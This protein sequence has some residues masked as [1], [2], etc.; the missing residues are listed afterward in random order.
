M[1]SCVILHVLSFHCRRF[2]TSFFFSRG[3]RITEQPDPLSHALCGYCNT[4]VITYCVLGNFAE[5]YEGKGTIDFSGA[6][7]KRTITFEPRWDKKASTCDIPWTM[8]NEKCSAA[9]KA[10]TNINWGTLNKIAMKHIYGDKNLNTD[11]TFENDGKLMR[12]VNTWNKVRRNREISRS[13]L[14]TPFAL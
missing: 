6:T 11:V 5:T 2:S 1:Y 3:K 12:I 13:F 4:R 14:N 10:N 9:C 7:K 8:E